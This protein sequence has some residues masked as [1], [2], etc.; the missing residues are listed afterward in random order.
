MAQ[1]AVAGDVGHMAYLELEGHTQKAAGGTCAMTAPRLCRR[2]SYPRIE[3]VGGVLRVGES[4]VLMRE[5]DGVPAI[6]ARLAMCA[7]E[8]FAWTRRFHDPA[9]PG[10]RLGRSAQHLLRCGH[11]MPDALVGILGRRLW[12]SRHELARRQSGQPGRGSWGVFGLCGQA[13]MPGPHR[14]N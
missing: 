5:R 12:P 9:R 7:E 10:A 1:F 13:G 11:H 14:H 8:T 6:T 3:A 2:I 4:G